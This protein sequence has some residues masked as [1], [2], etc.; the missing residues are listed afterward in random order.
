MIELERQEYDELLETAT[1]LGIIR[2]IVNDSGNYVDAD[3]LRQVLGMAG[4]K[5]EED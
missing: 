5:H 3:I 1:K 4:L 2:R